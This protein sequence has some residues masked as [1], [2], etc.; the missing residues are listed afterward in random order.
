MAAEKRKRSS[1]V[2]A[3]AARRQSSTPAT[4]TKSPDTRLNDD[5][6]A[7]PAHVAADALLPVLPARQPDDLPPRDYKSVVER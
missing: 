3:T 1:T 4:H 2:R 5:A 6:A 7:L